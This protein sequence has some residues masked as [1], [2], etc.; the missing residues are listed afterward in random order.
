MVFDTAY[1]GRSLDNRLPDVHEAV[2]REVKALQNKHAATG[3]LKSG[4]TLI[5][6]EDIATNLLKLT[7]ADASKSPLNSLGGTSL[8]P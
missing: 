1:L 6:F 4:A 3:R 8:E 7:I 5:A 2:T